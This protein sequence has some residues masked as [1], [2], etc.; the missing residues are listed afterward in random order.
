MV[1]NITQITSQADYIKSCS[2]YISM[3]PSLGEQKKDTVEIS[4]TP[5][6]AAPEVETKEVKK[7]KSK[8]AKI[9]GIAL[10]GAG[11]IT[12]VGVFTNSRR[13][14]KKLNDIVKKAL[15]KGEGLSDSLDLTK[16]K[17][18]LQAGAKDE[19]VM[20]TA[21]LMNNI[22]NFKDCYVLPVM[23]KIPGLRWMSNKSSALYK[24]TGLTMTKNSYKHAGDAY[25]A[26]DSK[27][28]T[29]L[30]KIQDASI[31]D[32][33]KQLLE[34][35]NE[36]LSGTFDP[37]N[38]SRIVDGK[39]HGRITKIEKIMDEF[40]DKGICTA[41]REKFNALIKRAA[42]TKGKDIDGFGT[43]ISEDMLKNHKAAYIE[44]LKAARNSINDIDKQIMDLLE[45]GGGENF[46]IEHL[47]SLTKARTNAAKSLNNAIRIE[48]NDLFDKMR[49]IKIGCA[50]TDIMGIASST[51]LLGLYMAQAEDKDERVG[52]ALTTGVPL[53]LGMGATTFTTM[54]MYTGLKP[55]LVGAATT[56]VANTIGKILN[57]QY[58][59]SHN[60][61]DKQ[62]SIPTVES[63]V[64]ELSDKVTKTVKKRTLDKDTQSAS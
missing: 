64:E 24:T 34:K 31:A 19:R 58:K 26:F 53:A 41:V 18:S 23:D 11:L 1:E 47:Q 42:K 56:L 48:A 45:K 5:A 28:Q 32:E 46:P 52:I 61:E 17:E 21:G 63:A 50:P 22:A 37:S 13:W 16:L 44:P 27:V 38:V 7:E 60:V 10:I 15:D 8:K 51:G 12:L 33:V 4:S 57:N 62:A 39:E 49:D 2:K 59:K 30:K 54:K 3:S 55:L 25:K 29:V 9:A 20:K 43:F 35:R 36:V 14:N 6:V 40:D